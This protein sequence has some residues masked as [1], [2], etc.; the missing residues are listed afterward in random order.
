MVGSG[1][2]AETTIMPRLL[3]FT[4]TLLLLLHST[5]CSDIDVSSRTEAASISVNGHGEVRAVPDRASFSAAVVNAGDE[6]EATLA[7]NAVQSENLLAALQ[8]AGVTTESLRTTGVRLQPVWS[9]RPRDAQDD[10]QPRITGYQAHNR[11]EVATTDLAG[12]GTLLAIAVR[13]GASDIQGVHFNLEDDAAAR[14]DAIR[15]ATERALREAQ[16][17]ASAAGSSI[18]RMLELRLDGASSQPPP[19]LRASMMDARAEFASVPVAPGEVTVS[20]SVS[21]RL[22]LE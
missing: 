13:A 15:I 21:V 22:A 11:L 4:S 17:L 1:T 14:A 9:S 5:G 19:M 8:A 16:T 20:A 7:A 12:V 2:L 6:A 3:I 18:G 10:W